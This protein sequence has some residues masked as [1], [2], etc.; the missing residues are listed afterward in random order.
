MVEIASERVTEINAKT[1]VVEFGAWWYNHVPRS[2]SHCI[3][4]RE[5]PGKRIE[6]RC[7]VT[8][9][10][11]SAKWQTDLIEVTGV[12]TYLTRPDYSLLAAYVLERL[13]EAL[14][15]PIAQ[16]PLIGVMSVVEE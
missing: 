16:S 13:R 14:E 15:G 6:F 10:T 2:R 11:Q 5:D 4:A 9:R 12:P 8:R 3:V 7:V 1:R